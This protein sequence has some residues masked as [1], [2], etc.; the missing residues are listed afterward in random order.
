MKT[1]NI[2]AAIKAALLLSCW[3]VPAAYSAAPAALSYQATLRKDGALFNGTAAM[4]FRITNSDASAVYWTSG[5]TAVAVTAGLFRYPL[6]SPNEA[7]FSAVSWGDIVPYVQMQVD[8]VWLPQEPLYSSAYSLHAY[9]AESSSGTTFTAYEGDIRIST[10]SGSKGI[11]FQDGTKQY[12]ASGW[13]VSGTDIYT[14]FSGNAGIGVASPQARLDV[15]GGPAAQYSQIWRDSSGIVKASM[16]NSGMLYADGSL[17]RNMP[18]GAD[19]LGSHTANR[20]LDIAGYNLVNVSTISGYGQALRVGSEMWLMDSR[21]GIGT[22]A[23]SAQL[24]ISTSAGSS[25]DM[26]VLSTGIVKVVRMT[27]AGEVYAS[28]YYGDGS[29]LTGVAGSG[30]ADD[31]GDH[32]LTQNLVTGSNWISSDGSSAGLNLDAAG[33]V[34][35]GET[36]GS[37]RLDVRGAAGNYIQI[38]RNNSG[39]IQASM[40]V[41]GMLYA[42]G[43]QL[44]NLSLPSAAA[45]NLNMASYDIIGVSTLTVSSITSSGSSVFFGKNILVSNL[46]GGSNRC[47][48]V[49]AS[50]VIR[51]KG[52]GSDCGLS[53]VTG[54]NLGDYT[55]TQNL[56]VGSNWLSNDGGGNGL[57]VGSAGNVGVGISG[58]ATRLDV[59]G[60]GDGYTQF[61]R[62]SGGTIIASMTET[63][64][65]YAD[66]SGLRN[67]P[68]GADDLGSHIAVQALDMAGYQVLNVSSLS[69][70]QNAE[71]SST[72]AARYGGVYVSTH[73]YLAAGGK[74]YGDGSQLT[75]ITGVADNLGN[76]TAAQNLNMASFDVNNVS[77]VTAGF[78]SGPGAGVIFTTNALVMGGRLGIDTEAPQEKLHVQ[79]NILSSALSA[80]GNRCVYVDSNGVFRA[81][82]SDCGTA[83]GAA[84]DLGSHIMLQNLNTNGNWISGDNSSAGLTVA[85]TGNVGIGISGAATRLDVQAGA[86]SYVQF[87]RN[88][89]GVVVASMTS[90][91]LLYADGSG[92]RNAAS[93]NLGNH[94]ATQDL[95][96]ASQD[97]TNVSTI[98]AGYLTSTGPGVVF[99]TNII[100][101]EGNVGINTYAPQERLHVN[102][103][104]LSSS[105]SGA[106]NRCVYVDVNGVLHAK[107]SDCGL[108]SPTGDD[109]GSHVM[110]QNLVAGTGWLSGDGG[111]EGIRIDALGNVSIGDSTAGGRL[112]VRGSV[113]NYIQVW[114]NVAGVTQASMSVAGVLYAD[115]SGLRNLPSTSDN[116]GNH[117]MTQNLWT[118]SNWI[119][120]DG[121]S[122]GIRVDFIGNIGIGVVPDVQARLDVKPGAGIYSQLWRDAGGTVVASMTAAGMFYADASNLRNI[123]SS[124]DSL[125]S[126]IATTT[127]NMGG[128]AINNAAGIT[129]SGQVTSYSSITVA[130]AAGF[131]AAKM[132]FSTGVEI[133]SSAAGYGGVLVS[134]HIFLPAGA[135]YYGDGSGLTAL[136]ASNLGS[137]SLADARLSANVPLL[138]GVNTFVS[139]VTIA[140]ASGA[141]ANRLM[142]AQKVELSSAAAARYGGLQISTHV[143][144]PAGAV[145]YGDGSGL[146]SLSATNVSAGTLPDT[147][148]SA[149]VPLLDAAQQFDG[150]NIFSSS[151]T[152]TSASG[153]YL[154]RL[155][156]AQKVELSSAAASRYGG[157]Q[158]STHVYLAPGARYYGDGSGITALSASNIS[159]GALS[160]SRLSSNVPLLDASQQFAGVNTFSSSV[161]V[162]SASGASLSRLMLAQ[163]VELSSA[164]AS[165][166]GGVQISTHVYL[167]AGAKYYGDGS[168]LSGVAGADNLGDHTATTA[169]SMAGYAVNNAGAITANGQLTTYSSMTV[170]GNL[171]VGAA[172]LQL[173][174]KVEISSTTAANKGGVYISTNIYLPAGAKYY[175][176]GSGLSG[177][178]D[179]GAVQKTGAT[180][181]GQLTLSG[182]S[183]T[184]NDADA[185]T[186]TS[187]L[188]FNNFACT[189]G[190]KLTADVNG[191]IICAADVS[192]GG[193]ENITG[194]LTIG[195][196]AGGLD[197]VN[198]GAITANGQLTTYSSVTVAGSLGLGSARLRLN[199]NVEISSATAANKGGVYIST[200]VY[201][202]AGAKFYGDGSGLTN[203]PGGVG[204][205]NPAIAD[206]NMSGY[207]I[208]NVSSITGVSTLRVNGDM[209][210]FPLAGV[211][212]RCVYA[213]ASGVLRVKAEDCGTAGGGGAET[214]ANPNDPND[215]LVA[216]GDFCV[217]Q[218]EATVW[219]SVTGGTKYG[220]SADDY[221]CSDNGQD[222]AVG[223][224][225]TPIY[226]RSV[227]SE[228]PS[229]SMTWFQANIACVNSGKHL[230]TNA[231]WQAAV[232]GTPDPGASASYPPDCNTGGVGPTATNSG[233]S[234]LSSFG[235]ENM[236]GSLWE[237]VADW[238]VYSPSQLFWNATYGT[239]LASGPSATPVGGMVRGG[240]YD[241][242]ST[243]AGAFSFNTTV[244]PVG[245]AAIIGFRCAMR[246]R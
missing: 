245:A 200:N 53:G 35:I 121:D 192:G 98:T 64:L 177:V 126:H 135:R 152:V 198:A 44:R 60:A 168:A 67:L 167:P 184:I 45:R 110:A 71:I 100:V 221:P 214:C 243:V 205:A 144:L 91:G 246:L 114:R 31:L 157:V 236:V 43:S 10:T 77:T 103:N 204:M 146:T 195:N 87:W 138:G 41:L 147:R 11:I 113:G 190:D 89:G 78:L 18:T 132:R 222:C 186:A 178:T 182:S 208:I 148:L 32:T 210:N 2:F 172:K 232:A 6:G 3:L 4:E 118:G 101:A 234:C 137:G 211:G 23:P 115:G 54:D 102:G 88:S 181:T 85:A 187:G 92:I 24:H 61:W 99:S 226:A 151:L 84:D 29:G 97:I 125:G 194:V 160:D 169:L 124:A 34:G 149:N 212:N 233:G 131:A 17:M 7:Q 188:K 158:V 206:F 230:I 183:I 106:S 52:E 94:T 244:P 140:S 223:G 112:D 26:L 36:A 197:L 42:D 156:M 116:L 62:N 165:R 38:W 120:A 159:G 105:L 83:A 166:Y 27:G 175:G 237:W 130:G 235:V 240:A 202:P 30:G 72:T 142:M 33:N 12:S 199:P 127:L 161:T 20:D 50:G 49:D 96:L 16:T 217:D 56:V 216:V 196:D 219:S 39:I 242:V 136:S 162:T 109:L 80:P 40:T 179:A 143:Y 193:G 13:A 47:V 189:G 21:F 171:G 176:D 108:A 218:F 150:V 128:F 68:L 139:S 5:S 82:G 48:Y 86:G 58:A 46:T 164:A 180:M 81:K 15:Q 239:D 122:E 229:S 201:L 133:S 57:T 63:G 55:L 174:P 95:D 170:A 241:S 9:R 8:G 119:S 1:K 28:K 37:A 93:D 76:H 191:R 14:S 185:N 107:G 154:T 141:Y 65:L 51:A 231:E 203:V 207:N 238:G 104:I 209:M 173:N 123:P 215:K 225:G 228:V 155:M 19:G 220:E 79:G 74:Y 22:Y 70:A 73:V 227:V 129:A 66:S 75:G 117:L 224:G 163:K 69:L 59:Q 90:A 25:A 111:N 145:Y 153:A 134:T 213:D